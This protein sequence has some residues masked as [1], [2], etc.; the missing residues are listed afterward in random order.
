MTI[1]GVCSELIT[2][3]PVI[4]KK[5]NNSFHTF[6]VDSPI[7]TNAWNCATCLKK[8]SESN[9]LNDAIAALQIDIADI[10]KKQEEFFAAISTINELKGKHENFLNSLNTFNSHCET[11]KQIDTKV[12]SLE[13]KVTVL[14]NDN[15]KLR[16]NNNFLHYRFAAMEQHMY[17]ANIEIKGIPQSNN[18]NVLEILHVIANKLQI[19]ITKN[20]VKYVHRT[21]SN[22]N[23]KSIVVEFTS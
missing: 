20:D 11:L 18:E 6:C 3:K 17:A 7:N 15:I 22:H 21:A 9:N 13:N 8:T 5:C 4:C 14:E 1:C 10:K 12:L 23:V 2:R 19:Q 16:E